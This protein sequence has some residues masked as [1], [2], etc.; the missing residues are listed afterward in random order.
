M[1]NTVK[2]SSMIT[3]RRLGQTAAAALAA[4]YLIRPADAQAATSAEA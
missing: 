4:P 1:N 3:R 2:G